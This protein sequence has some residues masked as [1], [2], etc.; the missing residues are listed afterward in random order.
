MP[1]W[2]MTIHKSQGMT[3][4]KVE[5][6]LART[7]E[8]GQDYVALS[9]AR[10]LMGLKVTGLRRDMKGGNRQVMEFLWEKFGIGKPPEGDGDQDI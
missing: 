10:G 9:R 5:I 2:A 8:S 4:T 6:D 7:F 1:A 3:L